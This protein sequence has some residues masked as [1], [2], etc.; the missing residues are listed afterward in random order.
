MRDYATEYAEA[1]VAGKKEKCCKA[2]IQACMRFLKDKERTDLEWHPEL[3]EKHVEFAEKLSIYIKNEKRYVKF[4]DCMRGFQKFIICNLFGWYKDG[5]RRFNEM[6]CQLARKNSKSFLNS[7]LALD[8]ATLS[9]IK[10]G[11]IYCAGTNYANA[12]IVC[13]D[14]K[15][16]IEADPKLEQYFLIRS[17]SDNILFHFLNHRF[18]PDQVADD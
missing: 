18:Q 4:K 17:D 5:V 16:L 6:Y 9:A 3:A 8:F 2:E 7:F 1:V 11:Q 15:K 14:C 13:Q 12:S 10:D